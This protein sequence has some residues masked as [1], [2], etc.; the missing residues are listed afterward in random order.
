PLASRPMGDQEIWLGYD[1]D[2]GGENGDGAGLVAI[3][4]AKNKNG[5]HRIVE[6]L[7]LFGLDFEQQAE[8]ILKFCQKYNVTYIGMDAT[9]LGESVAQIVEKQKPG[10]VRRFVY[11]ADVKYQMVLKAQNVIDRGRL[12]FDAGSI[13][14][15]H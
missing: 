8:V 10:I 5:K 15:A 1:A 9:G 11:S 2:G 3:A 13:D 14:I 7:R 4:P 6:K 12:E